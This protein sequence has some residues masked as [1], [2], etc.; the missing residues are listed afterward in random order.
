METNDLITICQSP[1]S[2]LTSKIDNVL[3]LKT[4]CVSEDLTFDRYSSTNKLWD[5]R[6]K[7]G[8]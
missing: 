1:E 6:N 2:L 5:F 8:Q 7:E 4:S 3:W